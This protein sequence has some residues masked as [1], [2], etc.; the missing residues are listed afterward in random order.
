MLSQERGIL[1]LIWASLFAREFIPTLKTL[2][3]EVIK[4]VCLL[5]SI[6]L[7]LRRANS[8]ELKFSLGRDVPNFRIIGSGL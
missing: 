5:V 7:K 6:L 3:F 2:L 4:V 1:L 8:I